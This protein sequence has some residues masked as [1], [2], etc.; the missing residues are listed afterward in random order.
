M[1]S[2][3]STAVMSLGD[4]SVETIVGRC[5]SRLQMQKSGRE[6]LIHGAEV[7]PPGAQV[8]DWPGLQPKGEVSEYQLVL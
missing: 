3:R 7:V 2:G 1:L 8:L 6:S 5:C 4:D